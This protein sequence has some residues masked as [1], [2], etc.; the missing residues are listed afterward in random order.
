MVGVKMT[1]YL[2]AMLATLAV[3]NTAKADD[4]GCTVFFC[5]APG[6]PP[7]PTIPACVGP[8]S[9]ALNETSSGVPGVRMMAVERG[10][11]R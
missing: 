11:D 1:P 7:W 3:T 10:G 5:A 4:Y 8:V 2:A 9:K 6:A